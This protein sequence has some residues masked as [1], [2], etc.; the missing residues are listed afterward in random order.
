MCFSHH[1]AIQGGYSTTSTD[2]LPLPFHDR[3]LPAVVAKIMFL[4][5]SVILLIGGGSASVHAGIP[6][7]PPEADIPWEADLRKQNSPQ[8][9][10]PPAS[11]PLE[12]DIPPASRPTQE[13]DSV[14]RSISGRYASYWN[15]FFLHLYE[16]SKLF[17]FK[18]SFKPSQ[19]RLTYF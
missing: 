4:F 9:R 17:S 11:R 19:F 12:T 16:F 3:L 14:I 10:P 13:A 15:A 6:P 8:S 2:V 18:I 7:A 1:L 5:V